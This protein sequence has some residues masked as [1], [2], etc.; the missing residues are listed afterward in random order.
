[1]TY[2]PPLP[3]LEAILS[4]GNYLLFSKPDY[5]LVKQIALAQEK[6]MVV[7]VDF[8]APHHL[9]SNSLGNSQTQAVLQPLQDKPAIFFHEN[10]EIATPTQL[11]VARAHMSNAEWN[12]YFISAFEL[13]AIHESSPVVAST[14]SGLWKNTP[15]AHGGSNSK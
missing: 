13:N 8:S 3:A 15:L 2:T 10:V 9:Y 12:H 6:Y 14:Y 1:M 5:Q 4:Q 11:Q 7:E